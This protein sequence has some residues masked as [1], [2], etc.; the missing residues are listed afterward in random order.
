MSR[1][2]DVPNNVLLLPA[3]ARARS[4]LESA[5]GRLVGVSA[6]GAP[7]VAVDGETGAPRAARSTVELLRAHLGAELTLLVDEGGEVV[8]TGVIRSL[9]E[10]G[11]RLV[12][13]A[14]CETRIEGERLVLVAERE[15]ELRCGK[16]RLV[17]TEDGKVLTRGTSL[18]QA[19]SGPN[20][21]QGATVEIN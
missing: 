5:F 2:P 10:S 9:E 19:S 17:L 1:S 21:I 6:R 14:G 8:I 16:A 20:R 15:I 4:A 13:A 7:L 12:S 11:R 18:V 3:P